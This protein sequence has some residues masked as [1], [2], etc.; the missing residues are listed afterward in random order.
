MSAN[1]RKFGVPYKVR[2]IWYCEFRR[3]QPGKPPE[4]ICAEY[5]SDAATKKQAAE[6]FDRI[7][8]GLNDE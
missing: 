1:F 6:I 3:G 8:K 2:G 7:L 5:Q 4:M